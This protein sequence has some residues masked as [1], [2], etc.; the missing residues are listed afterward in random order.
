VLTLVSRL[1]V[2]VLE[3]ALIVDGLG[4]GLAL[5]LSE[6]IESGCARLVVQRRG[7]R[8]RDALGRLYAVV[9]LLIAIG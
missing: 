3:F 8:R 1:A 9:R 6:R 4:V 7:G 5:V 2:Y